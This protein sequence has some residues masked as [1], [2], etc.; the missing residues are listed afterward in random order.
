MPS[1]G[2]A[3]IYMDRLNH[4]L[5]ENGH[6]SCIYSAVPEI[7]GYDNGSG[8]YKRLVL[9]YIKQAIKD[10][11]VKL[12][13]GIIFQ[14]INSLH[15]PTND[16]LDVLLAQLSR[17]PKKDIGIVYLQ[18]LFPENISEVIDKLKPYFGTIIT[19]SFDVESDYIAE[20]VR[21][22]Q[23]N[24]SLTLLETFHKVKETLIEK[25]GHPENFKLM[26]K[27][28]IPEVN[29]HLH[30]CHFH[31]EILEYLKPSKG[32]DFVLHPL[33]SDKWIRDIDYGNHYQ[34]VVKNPSD[35]TIGIINPIERKGKEIIS[36]VIAQTPYNF[37]ILQGGW[38]DGETFV[39]SLKE[40]YGTDFSDRVRLGDYS[41]DIVGFFD[42]IDVFLFPSWIEG[43]GQVGHEALLRRTPVI[44]TDYPAIQQA[45]IGKAKY[46]PLTEYFNI[47]SWLMA[48]EDVFNNQPYWHFECN[49]AALMLLNRTQFNGQD[50]L[51]YLQTVH[52]ES[53][54]ENLDKAQAI[55]SN[56]NLLED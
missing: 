54:K 30:L 32:K 46:V 33:I 23:E 51:L 12:G 43:Y 28:N 11:G 37:L 25:V 14:D 41:Q 53:E 4:F 38:G 17:E 39:A 16:Y 49:D 15:I 21:S 42:M 1:W 36:Q 22:N 3:E 9:P 35:Y 45:T 10:Y 47:E 20:L 13:G 24:P 56:E 8:N 55:H 26:R 7:E 6:E 44:T 2:G 40:E 34:P 27:Q 19:T 18:T 29:Y 52:S 48:I 50:F 5:N 31:H